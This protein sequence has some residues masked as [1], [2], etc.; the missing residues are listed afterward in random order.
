M[1]KSWGEDSNWDSRAMMRPLYGTAGDRRYFTRALKIFLR[2]VDGRWGRQ[3][4]GDKWA[5]RGK[6][7]I[8]SIVSTDTQRRYAEH[9]AQTHVLATPTCCKDTKHRSQTSMTAEE[10]AR[11]PYALVMKSAGGGDFRRLGHEEVHEPHAPLQ[12]GAAEHLLL[13]QPLHSNG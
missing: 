12:A 11:T 5:G 4:Y 2:G 13:T 3:G 10:Q 8:L 9:A 6:E 7:K 1:E